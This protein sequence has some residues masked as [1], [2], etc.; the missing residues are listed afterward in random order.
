MLG[1]VCVTCVW[2]GLFCG[3]CV[4]VLCVCVCV[5]VSAR[6]DS[7]EFSRLHPACTARPVGRTRVK[8]RKEEDFSGQ[9]GRAPGA[10]RPRPS[11]C[12]PHGPGGAC[13]PNTSGIPRAPT[14][15]SS[16]NQ[17]RTKTVGTK[18]SENKGN[19]T[20]LLESQEL[21]RISC[22]PRALGLACRRNRWS[23]VCI[24][25]NLSK[26]KLSEVLCARGE[27]TEEGLLLS[28]V[29]MLLRAGCE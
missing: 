6:T 1:R 27:P 12:T 18:A 9:N 24:G 4:S 15:P 29:P 20:G 7:E 17:A 22:E 5:G 25:Y 21:N 19:R 16:V 2:F 11:A 26:E 13:R 8:E 3:C 10:G 23:I 14:R 28:V